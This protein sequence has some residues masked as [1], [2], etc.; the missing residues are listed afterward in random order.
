MPGGSGGRWLDEIADP[1]EDLSHWVDG[2]RVS[3]YVY[4]SWYRNSSGHQD[5]MNQIPPD[6]GSDSFSFSCP[7][8]YAVYRSNFFGGSQGVGPGY[9]GGGCMSRTG[10]NATTTRNI[11]REHRPV[12]TDIRATPQSNRVAIFPIEK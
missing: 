9:T 3:D 1:V 8:G 4:P 11:Q 2:V 7:T 6:A 5:A 12:A 10:V